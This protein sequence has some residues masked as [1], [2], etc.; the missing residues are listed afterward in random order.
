MDPSVLFVSPHKQDGKLV[1]S[2]L[3]DISIPVV[4]VA[5]VADATAKL[6][7][8]RFGVA[9]CEARL[10]DGTWL[11][12]LEL[13]RTRGIELVVTDA[14]ADARFWAMAINLGAYDMLAQPFHR[15]EV[16]RVLSGASMWRSGMGRS[17]IEA[18]AAAS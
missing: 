7:A 11:N 13:T 1:A 15:T 4:H 3:A 12:L 16:R 14:F 18:R 2:M 6:N 5:N 8:R 17:T 10:E 9:L